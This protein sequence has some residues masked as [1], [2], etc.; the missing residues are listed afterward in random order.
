MKK[1]KK[2]KK[3][4]VVLPDKPEKGL[5]A[6]VLLLLFSVFLILFG[7]FFK[8]PCTAEGYPDWI[9]FGVTALVLGDGFDQV[10]NLDV[11]AEF[12]DVGE[13]CMSFWLPDADGELQNAWV[14]IFDSRATFSWEISGNVQHREL[15]FDP[16]GAAWS[17]ETGKTQDSDERFAVFKL[18]VD[19]DVEE[20]VISIQMSEGYWAAKSGD[21]KKIR[22]PLIASLFP[23]K[24]GLEEGK[25]LI[26][27][28]ESGEIEMNGENE[29]AAHLFSFLEI[30][31]VSSSTAV[32]E[33]DGW[34][35]PSD[36]ISRKL[37][38]VS[39]DSYD[40]IMGIL[41][42]RKEPFL[43]HPVVEFEDNKTP[44][45]EEL[46]KFLMVGLGSFIFPIEV[47]NVCQKALRP[48]SNK[49]K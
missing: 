45:L 31:G 4:K 33:I 36:L 39:P 43:F 13:L 17:Q 40:N 5:I 29:I 42:W 6:Y 16:S 26:E 15:T 23:G 38:N 24:S 12:D 37:T 22:T 7:I 28:L 46:F 8:N 18:G 49:K 25:R 14:L 3:K 9:D 2:K 21:T 27:G 47:G 48:P 19:D 34:Y 44:F 10:C 35:N 20:G 41:H 32:L 11:D 30:D 1:R